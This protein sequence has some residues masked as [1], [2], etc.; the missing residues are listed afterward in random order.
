MKFDII[1][2]FPK[3]LDSYLAEAQL[4]RA[5]SKNLVEIKVHDLRDY[6]EDKHRTTDDIPYGGG[7]GMVMKVEPVFKNVEAILK[8]GPLKRKDIRIV[9]LS[10]K[11]RF[12]NQK[13]AR[14]LSG[15]FKQI[16]LICGRY[17][18]MDER[19]AK[20]IAD[21]EISVGPYILSG[22]ELGAAII[23]DSI[24]RLIPGVVGN[25][26]S[27]VEESYETNAVEY[28]QFTRPEEFKG[29]KVPKVLLSG[30]H[31]KIKEWRN[32]KQKNLS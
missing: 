30:D 16:I 14:E 18:G 9:L 27:L 11:G 29:W 6:A 4:K 1:T 32:K 2:I 21:E 26:T 19:V 3:I 5:V 8:E 28:P 17:E 13:K 25:K 23:A 12:Y 20:Y 22:G 7:A 15:K 24:S 31:K 10:A